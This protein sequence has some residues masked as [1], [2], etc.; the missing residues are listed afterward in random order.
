M[1]ARSLR[2]AAAAVTFLTRIPVG[3]LVLDAG[4]VGRGAALFPA[5]GAG[6]GALVGVIVVELDGELTVLLAAAA[7]VTVEAA[8]DGRDPPRRAR[9]HRGRPRS[10]HP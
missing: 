7:A 9:R 5:V 3:R 6:I 4:D 1:P 10:G 2:A 8:P